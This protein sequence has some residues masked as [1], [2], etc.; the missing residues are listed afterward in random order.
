[1]AEICWKW[2]RYVRN[3]LNMWEKMSEMA[4]ICE[5]RLKYGGND[6]DMREMV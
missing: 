5:K 4:L 2:Q 3:G 1:M 6:L